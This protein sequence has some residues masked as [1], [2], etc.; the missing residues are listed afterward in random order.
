MRGIVGRR[1]HGAQRRGYQ[2]G[3]GGLS[4]AARFE[5]VELSCRRG[6]RAVFGDLGFGLEAGGALVLHG[7]NGSG[8]SSLLRILAGLL[9]PAGGRLLWNGAPVGDDAEAHRARLHYVGHLDALK[10]LMTPRETLRFFAAMR[11]PPA[12]VEPALERLG[13]AGLADLPARYLSA[14]QRRRVA[15]ARLIAS[16]AALWLLD[17]PTVTLDAEASAAL[18]AMMADH[19]AAG[20]MIVLATHTGI[21]LDGAARLDLTRFALAPARAEAASGFADETW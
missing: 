9:R 15:L 19:R 12:K 6:G 16:P 11:G 21:A 14:G 5:A 2:P 13:L 8:K 7:P 18:E 10:P 3:G 17:E 20:G 4:E 1:A